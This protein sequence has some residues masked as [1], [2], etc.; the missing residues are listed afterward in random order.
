MLCILKEAFIYKGAGEHYMD[1]YPKTI[2]N[3]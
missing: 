2:A 1:V 3:F